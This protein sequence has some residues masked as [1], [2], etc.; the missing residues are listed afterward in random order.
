[1]H[2][3]DSTIF[4][5][6]RETGAKIYLLIKYVY[7]LFEKGGFVSEKEEFTLSEKGGSLCL[8]REVHFVRFF[9]IRLL[10]LCFSSTKAFFSSMIY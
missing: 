4:W 1:M 9:L 3:I 8:K 2:V 10:M 6:Y 5:Q 7:P